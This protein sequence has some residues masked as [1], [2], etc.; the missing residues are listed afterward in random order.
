MGGMMRLA[1]QEAIYRNEFK[2]IGNEKEIY[3]NGA[4]RST[5]LGL[6]VDSELRNE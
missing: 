5:G 1:I 2:I 6:C 4:D 3:G